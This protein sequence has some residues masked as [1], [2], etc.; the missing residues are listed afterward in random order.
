MAL[1]DK[2]VTRD[3]SVSP[4]TREAVIQ[5]YAIQ[6]LAHRDYRAPGRFASL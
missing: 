5:I 1:F 6:Y 4:N 2:H 3:N